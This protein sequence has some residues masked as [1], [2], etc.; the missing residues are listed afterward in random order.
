M[1]TTYQRFQQAIK[2]H[3]ESKDYDKLLFEWEYLYSE[4]REHYNTEECIC[5]VP[6]IYVSYFKHCTIPHKIIK[7]GSTCWSHFSK[8]I[9]EATRER[10]N[11]A[12]EIM[13]HNKKHAYE[14]CKFTKK[15][16]IKH[17]EFYEQ[18][19]EG[20][21]TGAFMMSKK[22]AKYFKDVDKMIKMEFKDAP[23]EIINDFL[24]T[25]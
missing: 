21:K 25:V 12:N 3:S 11:K 6:I 15:I 14:Y 20:K 19:L 13:K 8:D 9:D 17:L 10:C 16:K 24:K 7:I 18:M 5:A 23:R 1:V 2:S 22:Q 4:S